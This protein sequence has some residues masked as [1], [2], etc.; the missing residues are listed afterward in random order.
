MDFRHET[1]RGA[2]LSDETLRLSEAASRLGA[3]PDPIEELNLLDCV[4]SEMH[5]LADNVTGPAD[6]LHQ[7]SDE[8]ERARSRLLRK[9][10]GDAAEAFA[11]SSLQLLT[12]YLARRRNT[13]DTAQ[14][15]KEIADG[16]DNVANSAAGLAK[17]IAGAADEASVLV[18]TMDGDAPEEAKAVVRQAVADV[19]A[20]VELKQEEIATI[21][22][23]L[24]K[25]GKA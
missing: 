10:H 9:W 5:Y 18:I 13:R 20:M 22:A 8:F 12:S 21:G 14:A 17:Q 23:R 15:G 2:A 19:H 6:T 3:G 24:D 25:V 4:P 16:L 1:L 7:V 11:A